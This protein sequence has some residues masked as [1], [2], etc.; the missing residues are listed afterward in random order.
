MHEEQST[1]LDI[2]GAD[3]TPAAARTAPKDMGRDRVDAVTLVLF[4]TRDGTAGQTGWPT[5]NNRRPC[6]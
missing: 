5:G 1:W 4:N 3:N 2:D 6:A